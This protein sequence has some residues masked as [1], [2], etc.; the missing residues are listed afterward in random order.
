VKLRWVNVP[1]PVQHLLGLLLGAVLQG[2]LKHKLFTSPQVGSVIGL[3]LVVIGVG[4]AVWAVA[5][6]GETNIDKPTELL[7]GGPYSL[8]RNPMYVAWTLLYLGIGLTA[9][10]LW[11]IALLPFVVAFTHINDVRREERFLEEEFGEA[12]KQYRAQVRRYF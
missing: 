4:I 1:I 9:N 12:Y 11:I 6:A 3:P 7:T 8:S 10:S 5:E 2:A